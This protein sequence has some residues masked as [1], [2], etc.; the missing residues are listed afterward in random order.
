MVLATGARQAGLG[1]TL[2]LATAWAVT[3]LMTSVLVGVSPSDPMTFLV[4]GFVL[5]VA[6]LAG[7]LLPARRATRV[8]PVIA[9]RCD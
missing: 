9:L 4:V 6:T 7:C 8:D 3:R 2:G 1:L 5:I